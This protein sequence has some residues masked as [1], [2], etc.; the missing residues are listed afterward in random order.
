LL[1]LSLV[2]ITLILNFKVLRM[3]EAAVFITLYLV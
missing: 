2:G 3:Q 1:V